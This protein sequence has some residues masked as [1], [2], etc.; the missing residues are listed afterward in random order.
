ML[1]KK[2]DHK[3]IKQPGPLYLTGMAGSG[4]NLQLAI[5]YA[6]L[7]REGVPLGAV[8]A[9]GQDDRRA[10]DA[11]MMAVGVG[12][13]PSFGLVDDRL[14]GGELVAPA[15]PSMVYGVGSFPK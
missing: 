4:Q 2:F 14:H 13:L 3:A 11:L 5:R 15:R 6:R 9:P 12:L 1:G 8:L 10:A 7:E